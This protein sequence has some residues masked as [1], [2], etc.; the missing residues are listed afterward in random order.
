MFIAPNDN[1]GDHVRAGVVRNLNTYLQGR[2]GQVYTT[3]VD[4]MKV[5]GQL[6]GVPESAKAVALYYNKSQITTPPTN[7][8]A[9]LALVQGG[10]KIVLNQ[11]AYHSFGFW[12][13]FGGQLLDATGQCIADQGGFA[14][15]MQYL[16]DLKQA[17]VAFTSNAS[18]ADSLFTSGT[19]GM[20]IN[21][22]WVLNEYKTALGNNL[23]V[24]LMPAG[25]INPAG[26]LNGIDG[27]YINPNTQNFTSTVELALF[28]TNQASSQQFTN[29][30]GHIPIRTDVASTDPL[31]NTFA[32]ASAQGLPR[33]QSAAFGN[34][35]SP[36]GDMINN[37]LSGLVSPA[38]GV[39]IACDT[40]NHLNG[41]PVYKIYL[42]LVR[43]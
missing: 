28:M 11:N 43:R 39:M 36:F 24:A 1:L 21:G 8:A 31:I 38:T 15:A 26:P 25:P 23:G 4:G 10:K 22:P 5:V 3:V 29:I 12:R 2:L 32:Q 18:Q 34:Y 13:A 14:S 17:G 30:G 16:V 33:P 6:Y 42:P 9:L 20:I 41:F 37:V 40:M 35:W 19:V 7:T 27:F